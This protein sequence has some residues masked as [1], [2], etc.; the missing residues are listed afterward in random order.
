MKLREYPL[1]NGRFLEIHCDEDPQSPREWDNLGTMVCWHTRNNLGDEQIVRS[2]FSSAEEVRKHIESENDV[3]V[4]LP[5]YL[6]DHSGLTMNTTGF[7]CHWDSGQVGWIYV[8][9]EKAISEFS[10]PPEKTTTALQKNYDE[11]LAKIQKI[12][13][14]EVATYDQFLQGDVYGFIIREANCPTCGCDGKDS[15]E[16]CW[17]FFGSNLFENGIADHLDKE[18]SEALKTADAIECVGA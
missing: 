10:E 15:G 17:G 16:S 13:V 18:D 12:L 3:A 5:L 9:M 7:D 4:I 2:D 14:G 11:W 6:Y 1:P 8:T